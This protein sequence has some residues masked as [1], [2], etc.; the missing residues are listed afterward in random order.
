[1]SRFSLLV[2]GDE[3]D[4]EDDEE[5]TDKEIT[6]DKIN[7]LDRLEFPTVRATSKVI[8]ITYNLII[9]YKIFLIKHILRN[10]PYHA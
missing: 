6:Q 4:D 5:E 1:M 9:N 7:S 10:H 3:D 8:I 2:T